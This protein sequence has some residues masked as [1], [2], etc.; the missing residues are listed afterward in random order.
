M[1]SKLK[2]GAR[3]AWTW[4]LCVGLVLCYFTMLVAAVAAVISLFGGVTALVAGNT[5]R[6]WELMGFF[7]QWLIL[8]LL[9]RAVAP[10]LNALTGK[11]HPN[12]PAS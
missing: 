1:R 2:V 9:M 11:V 7:A 3:W 10:R 4:V 8:A 12:Q 5:G 6:G